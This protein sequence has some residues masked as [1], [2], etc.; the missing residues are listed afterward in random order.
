MEASWTALEQR[1]STHSGA[2][3]D[4]PAIVPARRGAPPFGLRD[5]SGMF[6]AC[7]GERAL[8]GV[9]LRILNEIDYGLILATETARVSFAN[10]AALRECS[11]DGAM[12]L[13][14]GHVQP[15]L[16]REHDS[17]LRALAACAAGRRSMLTL[18]GGEVP[19]PLAVVPMKDPS[20]RDSES[21]ALLVLGKRHVCEP[22]SVDFFAMSHCLTATE[23]S[24]LKGL[25][26]G[27]RP[28]DIAKQSGVAISTVRSQISSIRL[29]TEATS[30]A[31]LIRMVTIL[32]P[33][34][35]ALNRTVLSPE[36][37][38]Q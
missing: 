27:R 18:H 31:D 4:F 3:A 20:P 33:I 21:V 1:H 6:D 5:H 2:F 7:V 37:V 36:V 14:E 11:A 9:L 35:S 24:V 25:C 29:K 32:P 13:H 12:W 26:G 38:T 15:R 22:L 8:D 28:A 23:T 17:F 19:L 16:D 34:L 30:I 10:H